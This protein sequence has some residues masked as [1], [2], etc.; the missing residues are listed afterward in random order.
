MDIRWRWRWRTRARSARPGGW[1]WRSRP[2]PGSTTAA[3]SDIGIVATEAATNVVRHAG[4]GEVL[5]RETWQRRADTGLELRLRGPGPRHARRR[6][7]PGGWILQPGTMGGGFGAMRRLADGVLHLFGARPRHRAGLPLLAEV[8]RR[9]QRRGAGRW[10]GSPCPSRVKPPAGTPGPPSSAPDGQGAA[11]RRRAGA[12]PRRRSGRRRGRPDLPG[13]G[14]AAAGAAARR[15][16][17]GHAEHPRRRGRRGAD[18]PRPPRGPLRRHRK[19]QRG[20]R[21]RGRHAQP[22]LPQRDRRPPDAQGPGVRLS[23]ARTERC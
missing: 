23:L 2:T 13:S 3:R 8:A 19:H 18:R 10:P 14:R 21:H 16:A 20:D 4:K 1:R 9:R 5:V 11:G 17:R 12:R 7:L 6:R 22:G 15:P